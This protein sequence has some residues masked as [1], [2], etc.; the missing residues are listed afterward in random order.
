M[1]QNSVSE[2]TIRRLPLYLHV[3]E[4]FKNEGRASFSAT[5]LSRTLGIYHTLVRKDLNV[6]G[7]KG[8][9]RVGHMVDEAILQLKSYLGWDRVLNALLIGAG[10][11]ARALLGYR[12]MSLTGI[13]IAALIDCDPAK[14]GSELCGLTIFSPDDIPRL[15]R[16]FGIEAGII[17]TPAETAQAAADRLIAAG[18]TTLW[19]FTLPVLQTPES[20]V[21]EHTHFFSNMAIVTY[22]HKQANQQSMEATQ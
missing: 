7:L 5:E 10:N 17:T 12:E 6:A 11:L 3:L 21:V 2:F 22:K 4:Q 13:R 15:K 20:T 14:I 19:N 8:R 9:P 16:E 1:H 18:I